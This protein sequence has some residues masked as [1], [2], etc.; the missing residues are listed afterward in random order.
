MPELDGSLLDLFG[1]STTGVVSGHLFRAPKAL[2]E[3]GL[4]W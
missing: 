4:P 1:P 2:G 3:V